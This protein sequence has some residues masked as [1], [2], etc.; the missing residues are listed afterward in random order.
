MGVSQQSITVGWLLA[1]L[2][3][4]YDGFKVRGTRIF[5]QKSMGTGTACVN[6]AVFWME[7]KDTWRWQAS[8]NSTTI[9]KL[10]S[11]GVLVAEMQDSI[12][13][14]TI[15]CCLY[16][17]KL[18]LMIYYPQKLRIQL[19][20]QS[21]PLH[22]CGITIGYKCQRVIFTLQGLIY[23]L[24]LEPKV[25]CYNDMIAK[26]KVIALCLCAYWGSVWPHILQ[27]II[28]GYWCFETVYWKKDNT[29]AGCLDDTA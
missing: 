27:A 10:S 7:E 4:F 12:S 1:S 26:E 29:G 25:I 16:T 6:K 22:P 3:V 18:A 28:W 2:R 5:C 24:S 23:T 15:A 14:W 21:S 17:N 8:T 11:S 9:R 19:S 13:L 20:E